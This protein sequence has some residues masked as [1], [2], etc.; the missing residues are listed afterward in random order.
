MNT[1]AKKGKKTSEVERVIAAYHRGQNIF[2][3]ESVSPLIKYICE[4]EARL[5]AAPDVD[6]CAQQSARPTSTGLCAECGS[7]KWCHAV[8]GHEF[9]E[10]IPADA[11]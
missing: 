5:L 8:I 3:R 1:R 4:L 2:R 7:P 11:S 9:V 6:T 10:L